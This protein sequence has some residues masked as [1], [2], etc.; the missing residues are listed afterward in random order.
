[1]KLTL[2]KI[3]HVFRSDPD[4]VLVKLAIEPDDENAPWSGEIE[5]RIDLTEEEF[6]SVSLKELERRAVAIAR[7]T[8]Q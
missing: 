5:V 1:M 3:H 4:A 8:M 7:R 2:F 6:K